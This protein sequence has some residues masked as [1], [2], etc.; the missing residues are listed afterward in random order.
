[1]LLNAAQEE[2]SLLVIVM[3]YTRPQ[4]ID[5]LLTLF[6]PLSLL[7]HVT[8]DQLCNVDTLPRFA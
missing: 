1:M 6:G 4:S 5:N 8:L 3:R 2:D 7:L